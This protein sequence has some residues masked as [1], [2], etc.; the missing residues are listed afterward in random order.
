LNEDHE[1]LELF[2]SETQDYAIF[3]LD[4]QGNVASWNAG[5]R[6]F[7]GYRAKEII[8]QNFSIFYPPEDIG[9]GKPGRE[10][11]IAAAE[12]RL[13]DE[14]WRVR[15]DGTRFWANVVITALRDPD[16]TL[17]GYGKVTR[18]LTA[19]RTHELELLASEER[20]RRSFDDALIGMIVFGLDARY[21]RVNRAFCAI[22]GHSPETL[23]GLGREEITHPEDIAPDAESLRALL[24]G[25][26]ASYTREKRY[27]HAEGHYVWA[28]VSVTL[29]RD[30]EERPS[31]FI[32]QVLDITERR[33]YEDQL[34]D[35]ADHDPLTGLLNRRSFQR[36][37]SGQLARVK[38]FP[39]TGAVLMI[40][41]DHFKYYNDT[42]GHN[43][44]DELI[45]LIAHGLR[46][47]LRETDVIARLGATSSS[48][49]CPPK[50]TAAPRWSPDRCWKAC[51]RRLPPSRSARS[52]A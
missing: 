6:R 37:L 48:C 11:E 22:V 28:L 43:A 14:G 29:I 52:S 32:G 49:S 10:L 31:Y 51:E 25:E 47:R 24:A 18:D 40:D 35:I 42:K 19:R 3:R 38:R 44:G 9:A 1:L 27:I 45:V 7:K 16:G 15:K 46:D 12:G 30:G 4:T 2:V 5:A 20:F 41:L 13:E 8:G 17:R 21:T 33:R 50:T 26:A 23:T 34:V 36:E 39:G